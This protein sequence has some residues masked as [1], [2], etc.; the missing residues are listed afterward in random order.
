MKLS[1]FGKSQKGLNYQMDPKEKLPIR[2]LAPE[3]MT[4]HI[5]SYPTEVWSFG[6]VCWEIYA[7]GQEPYP[8]LMVKEVNERVRFL[9]CFQNS[10]H[11]FRYAEDSSCRCRS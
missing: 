10:T 11:H 9:C 2:W 8:G 7:D 3:T 5:F 6:I 1:D 4:D